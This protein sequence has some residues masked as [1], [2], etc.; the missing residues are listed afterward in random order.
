[1]LDPALVLKVGKMLECV[2]VAKVVLFPP[3]VE[4]CLR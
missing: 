1:M 3:E 4:V 2:E